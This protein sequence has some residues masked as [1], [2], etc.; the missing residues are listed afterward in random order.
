[1]GKYLSR[2]LKKVLKKKLYGYLG[3]ANQTNQG[4]ADGPEVQPGD[5]PGGRN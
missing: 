5:K 2:G 3:R 4:H 1:M